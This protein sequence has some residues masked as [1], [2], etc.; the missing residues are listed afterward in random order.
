MLKRLVVFLSLS[1]FSLVACEMV[2]R[3]VYGRV[4]GH[5]VDFRPVDARKRELLAE[6]IALGPSADPAVPSDPWALHPYLGVLRDPAVALEPPPGDPGLPVSAF[7]FVDDKSPIVEASPDRLVV[8]LF[9]GAVAWRVSKDGAA[10]IE[11]ALARVPALRGRKL[12]LV[13]TAIDGGKQPQ[14]LLALTW[15][16]SLGAHFDAVVDL[17]GYDEVVVAVRANAARG[18]NLAYPGGW[19]LQFARFQ[20]PVRGRLDGEIAT[21]TRLRGWWAEAFLLPQLRS[22]ALATLVWRAGDDAIARKTVDRRLELADRGGQLDQ[23]RHSFAEHGPPQA[24][25]SEDAMMADLVRVWRESSLQMHRLAAAN[26]ILYFHFLQ[27]TPYFPGSKP[28]TA[29]ER[30][31]ALL[32]DG[33]EARSVARAYPMLRDAALDL[34][35]AGVRFHDLSGAFEGQEAPLFVDQDGRIN[36]RGA[37]ILGR[38]VGE[39]MAHEWRGREE[40]EARAGAEAEAARQEAVG[41]PVSTSTEP[42]PGPAAVGPSPRPLT[43]EATPAPEPTPEPP[44]EP[45]AGLP[46]DDSAEEPS[47]EPTPTAVRVRR[48][49]PDP[50]VAPAGARRNADPEL[51]PGGPRQP[52]PWPPT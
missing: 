51:A 29:A 32:P 14:Q 41:S 15:L 33:I 5:P 45:S 34:R 30:R 18:V 12:V 4:Q 52:E 8:G 9:G 27:P 31:V 23:R 36:E 42:P 50:E 35:A 20:D 39:A 24:Y 11:A 48:G 40:V 46:T 6:A 2:A 44:V 19:D 13:R 3:W 7:G 37:A 49:P 26:G 16:L 43:E 1:V 17:D 21:M 10:A 28:M 47:Q 38:R 22:S 25:P